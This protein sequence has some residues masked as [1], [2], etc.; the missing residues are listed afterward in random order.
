VLLLSF[1]A[2]GALWPDPQL[3]RSLPRRVLTL[4]AAFEVLCGVLGVTTFAL[5]VYCGL[6][7]TRIGT[8]NLTPAAV[9]V[10]VWVGLVPI[11]AGLG[12]VFALFNPWRAA[13]RGAATLVGRLAPGRV[14]PP[15]PY[16]DRLGRWPAALGILGFAWLELVYVQRSDPA[17]L[18][19]L[20]LVYAT[21]Q[22][23][24]MAFY[25]VERWS[26][27]A[28]AFG[29]YFGLFARL[30]ALDL[31]GREVWRR[32]PLSGAASLVVL[33]GTTAL[34]FT[35]LGSTSFDGLSSTVMWREL[36][37][38]L[39]H[40]LTSLGVAP[41]PASELVGTLGLAAMI[42]VVA[43]VYAIGVRGVH[44]AREVHLSLDELRARFVHT[45]IPIAFAYV[46]AHYFT[47]LVYQGQ[48]IGFLVSDPLGHGNNLFGTAYATI[49]YHL[50][51]RAAVWY[52]QVGA[53]VCG[54][55]AAIV[56]AHDRSLALFPDRRV[57]TRS[58]QW[59]LTAMVGF[60]SLGLWLLAS[61]K[62]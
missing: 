8:R 20:M 46:L 10:V 40:A 22:L 29:V 59:M 60:T 36:A 42:G 3:E 5:L 55:V 50:L 12:D 14:G 17:T 9:Y 33:P 32:R 30:S 37:P 4:P 45:L 57:A 56:L 11:S 41:R 6:A 58:Q 27:R 34:L 15:L 25:G 24:G 62:R 51:S 47:F 13:A 26:T 28:D 54:H 48:A 44:A 35:M 38:K 23:L 19:M 31:R 43:G 18:A 52:L 2:L 7:G 21:V 49:D 39:E 61:I 53:L 16:P 1:V